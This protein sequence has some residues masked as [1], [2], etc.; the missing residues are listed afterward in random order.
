MERVKK[1][2][3]DNHYCHCCALEIED[4]DH[5]FRGCVYVENLWGILLGDATITGAR[6]CHLRSGFTAISIVTDNGRK[7]LLLAFGVYGNG[8]IMAESLIS[9]KREQ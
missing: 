1:K 7:V 2:I 4:Q 5:L 6:I 9:I 3:F 8:G